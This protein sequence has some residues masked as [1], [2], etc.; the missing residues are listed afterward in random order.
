MAVATVVMLP[1]I[2][3]IFAALIVS[4]CVLLSV[5][6]TVGMSSWTVIDMGY[7]AYVAFIVTIG[8]FVEFC[9]HIARDFM[10]A[11]GD[12][13]T[14]SIHALQTMGIAVFNGGVTTFLGIL[15]LLFQ[16]IQSIAIV[17]SFSIPFPLSPACLRACS[18]YR[19][20]CP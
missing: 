18:S 12:R 17:C 13:L 4:V 8:L 7:S 15:P 3:N 9:A 2:V 11:E 14:R 20:S 19:P 10:L 6:L 16:I 5:L 1:L